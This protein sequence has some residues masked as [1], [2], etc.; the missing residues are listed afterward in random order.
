MH[1]TGTRHRRPAPAQRCRVGRARNRWRLAVA[2]VLIG[3]MLAP[4]PAEADDIL[5][6]LG[7]RKRA[8]ARKV[9]RKSDMKE[10]SA[11]GP[12]FAAA[13]EGN[14]LEVSNQ[15]AT[16]RTHVLHLGGTDPDAAIDNEIWPA[17]EETYQGYHYFETWDKPLLETY[18]ELVLDPI[19]SRSIFL[20]GSHAG[21][22]VSTAFRDATRKPKIIIISPGRL[23][24]RLY[25]NYLRI[26]HGHR[27]NL[28]SDLDI[29]LTFEAYI[30]AIRTGRIA[31]G[32]D[33]HMVDGLLRVKGARGL[34]DVS[35]VLTKILFD[36]NHEEH[37]VFVDE[38]F[39]MPWMYPYLAPQ[40]PI[41][42]LYPIKVHALTLPV[43]KQDRVF[44]RKLVTRLTHDMSYVGN[45]SAQRAFA[46]M[47]T[48]T[49]RL[50]AHR[51]LYA[52]AEHA[53]LEALH[54]DPTHNVAAIRYAKLLDRRGD[55][56]GA[57]TVIETQLE[58]D[59]ESRNLKAMLEQLKPAATPDP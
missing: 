56:E 47:R 37:K 16:L 59:P 18:R 51:K 19:P 14:W 8:Q 31:A 22:F 1:R 20:A 6:M 21:R 11:F 10:T 12:F 57:V 53:F 43:V 13:A 54:L 15:Y 38:G 29:S 5:R 9:A 39:V 58:S 49:A 36:M 2:G 35:R 25:V 17:V 50:Y 27:V 41:L 48:A 45:P 26:S 3:G 34:R 24:D 28:P 40:G 55:R 32:S 46:G 7:R 4:V 30:E 23:P 33:I 42:R 44:W 52:E